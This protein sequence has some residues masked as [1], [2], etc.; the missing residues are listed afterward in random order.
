M[1]QPQKSECPGGA[2]QVAEKNADVFAIIDLA[3]VNSKTQKELDS[4]KAQF[5]FKG[6][7]LYVVTKG[8]ASYYEVRRWGQCRTCSTL[9]DL[10]GFLAQIG[11]VA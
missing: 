2:G 6:H 4:L 3:L 10:Q 8:E 9:H 7:E 5:A 1:S 11:G